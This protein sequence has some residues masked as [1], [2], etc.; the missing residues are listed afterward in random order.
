MAK[1]LVI[2][3]DG[4]TFAVLEPLARKGVIPFLGGLME[5]GVCGELLSVMPPVTAP[6]WVSFMTG[7]SPGNHGV[8][9]F[10]EVSRSMVFDTQRRPVSSRSIPY[11][12]FWSTLGDAGK[13]A[14]LVNIPMTYPATPVN[15]FMISGMLTPSLESDFVYPSDLY[16]RLGPEL[17]EYLLDVPLENYPRGR[18]E[19]FIR[20]LV[21]HVRQRAQYA[22][23]LLREEACDF[24][25]VVFVETDRLQHKLWH[26]LQAS[27]GDAAGKDGC[28]R[29]ST[30]QFYEILDSEL[31]EI[32]D[33]AGPECALIVM[34]DHGFGEFT[35]LFYVNRW[36]Q[37]NGYLTLHP[38]RRQLQGVA[39]RVMARRSAEG[40]LSPGAGPAVAGDGAGTASLRSL[41][42]RI[43][44]PVDWKKTKA[45]FPFRTLQ[46]IYL[47]VKGRQPEGC[48]K[49]GEEYARVREEIIA[50]LKGFTD[51]ETGRSLVQRVYRTEE[52]LQ[53]PFAR[54]M[55]DI[56]FFPDD[57]RCM[58]CETFSDSLFAD[59]D[60]SHG[61]GM[62]RPEGILVARGP[63]FGEERIVRKAR[64]IDLAP[65]ILHLLGVPV[66]DNLDGRVLEEI[67]NRQF[68]DSHPV[69]YTRERGQV[70]ESRED[71]EIYSAEETARLKER[72]RGIG[73]LE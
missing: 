37:E 15:G 66:P 24:F 71:D 43:L 28:A 1:L 19:E 54:E 45:F 73:Y 20:D 27:L 40:P 5:E 11:R 46:G 67:L 16:R 61:S 65:T 3:L 12:P 68:R 63:Q 4:G 2:G 48:V 10:L 9:D 60:W 22:K 32:A 58:G 31:R 50:R 6:A 42:K 17:G 35:R 26:R 53:G 8:F 18:E 70:K 33:L 51:P 30:L 49:Q 23:F 21:R 64:I 55:P 72:L 56:L 62:H 52:I 39:K 13:R 34:S 36:L 41:G 69:Q 25:M 29:D 57:F 59:T 7:K 47:N 14:G 38:L 44:D